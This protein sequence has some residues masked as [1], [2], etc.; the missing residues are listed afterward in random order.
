MTSFYFPATLDMLL[1]DY[2]YL[3]DV[4]IENTIRRRSQDKEKF[5][6]KS[7]QPGNHHYFVTPVTGGFLV[8]AGGL[9]PA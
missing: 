1:R 5:T 3:C 6:V 7:R 8:R 2:T 4:A 9:L